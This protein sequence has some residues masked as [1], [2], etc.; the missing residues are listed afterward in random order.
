V[1]IDLDLDFERSENKCLIQSLTAWFQTSTLHL[2]RPLFCI[3]NHKKNKCW[4]PSHILSWN[5]TGI[6]IS[7]VQTDSHSDKKSKWNDQ[8]VCAVHLNFRTL[9][10]ANWIPDIHIYL[11][12]DSTVTT[13][14]IDRISIQMS[15][16]SIH[17]TCKI[18]LGLV[19]S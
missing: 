10:I 17:K 12:Q 5:I 7:K 2:R 19:G 3:Q 8:F 16:I 13:P 18:M 6:S 14:R 9:R 15:M 11:L 1:D 4:N